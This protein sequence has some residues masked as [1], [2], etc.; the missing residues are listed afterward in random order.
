M[1][2]YSWTV[3]FHRSH[4]NTHELTAVNGNSLAYD[5]KGN[6]LNTEYSSLNTS[7]T[8]DMDNHLQSFDSGNFS[9]DAIG[10]RVSKG[11]TLFVSHGQQVI[12]EYIQV[13]GS[14]SLDR[15]YIH[16]TYVDDILAKIEH[17]TL[18][19]TIH[20][21]HVDRQYNVRGLTNSTGSILEL[22]AYSPYG[23]QTIIDANS[24]FK[25]Q[26]SAFA[27]AYGF[28]DRYIDS[29]MNLWYFKSRYFSDEFGRFI[30]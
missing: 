9:Y 29:E 18:P 5:L 6:L 13:G 30:S 7:Y 21:Y 25:I 14:Y 26:N 1:G 10:R 3:S 2:N 11:D 28:T 12:E 19:P 20:Y 15:S 17:D 24:G 4:N 23:K 22:Y 8:W 16:A 27:N